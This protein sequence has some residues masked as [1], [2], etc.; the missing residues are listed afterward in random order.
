MTRLYQL[1]F[2]L[3]LRILSGSMA[4]PIY[5]NESAVDSPRLSN[6]HDLEHLEEYLHKIP[7]LWVRSIDGGEIERMFRFKT[8]HAAW[9]KAINLV[10]LLSVR[11]IFFRGMGLVG[12]S[13]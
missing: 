3:Y 6:P 4:T 9:V 2:L 8:F 13:R 12:R 10:L 5:R 11:L 7:D 1:F